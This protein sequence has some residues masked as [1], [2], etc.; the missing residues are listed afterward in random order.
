MYLP[1]VVREITRVAAE[2]PDAIAVTDG[3]RSVSYAELLQLARQVTAT[4]VEGGVGEAQVAAF[5]G[6]RSIGSIVTMM[7]I[8]GAGAG[9]IAV[10]ANSSERS[11]MI[12]GEVGVSA[13]ATGLSTAGSAE[14]WEFVPGRGKRWGE[15][16]AHPAYAIFT[17]GSTGKPKGILVSHDSL[18]WHARAIRIAYELEPGDR[19]LHCSSLLFDVAIE[20]IWPT[21]AAGATVVVLPEP[22]GNLSYDRATALLSDLGISVCNIPSSYFAGWVEHLRTSPLPSSLRLVVV[23]SEPLPGSAAR[24]WLGLEQSAGRRLVNA[25]GLSEATVTSLIYE[26]QADGGEDACVPVGRPLPGIDVLIVDK[27]GNPVSKGVTGE[28]WLAGEGLSMGYTDAIADGGKFVTRRDSGSPRRWLRTGDLARWDGAEISVCGRT[29]D[30]VKIAGHRI[31]PAELLAALLNLEQVRDARI[32]HLDGELV[33]FLVGRQQSYQDVLGS[34]ARV[35]PSYM[36]PTTIKW[37]AEYPTTSGGKVDLAALGAIYYEVAARRDLTVDG[38]AEVWT[39]VLE[40]PD[41]KFSDDFFDL[42]GNSLAAARVI[43]ALRRRWDAQCTLADVF[44]SPRLED[45][46]ELL[47]S[48]GQMVGDSTGLREVEKV[49]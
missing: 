36:F 5:P 7:G 42:G 19:V 16:R 44:S 31:E 6:V 37:L 41:V 49:P 28:L 46:V 9:Y 23:G 8:L 38:L 43:S 18:A 3:V 32:L 34:L 39:S 20:E 40:V 21:L 48:R 25:Y 1:P 47:V 22:L 26:V 45:F 30:Q 27:S 13:I 10:D 33:A 11:K 24:A 4:L 35:L 29:D 12:F 17:S 2:H 15:A 14:G